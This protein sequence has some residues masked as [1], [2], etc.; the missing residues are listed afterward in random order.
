MAGLIDAQVEVQKHQSVIRGLPLIDLKGG[1]GAMTIPSS[2]KVLPP[3]ACRQYE[4]QIIFKPRVEL[5]AEGFDD[6]GA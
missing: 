6:T 5:N 2:I 4:K 3:L 1:V